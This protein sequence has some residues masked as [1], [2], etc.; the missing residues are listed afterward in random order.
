MKK[1]LFL[2]V[3]FTITGLSL[4]AQAPEVFNYSA[5]ARNGAGQP[6]I[7]QTIAIQFVI[8]KTSNLGPVLYT[9]NHIV[10]TDA[11]GLFNLPV[12]GGSVLNGSMS[13]INWS[14][15][16]YYLEVKLDITGGA[17]FATMGTTQLL[18]VPYALHAKTANDLVGKHYI[19]EQFG[20][21][22]IFHLWRDQSGEEH[23]LIVDLVDLGTSVFMDPT[24]LENPPVEIVYSLIQEFDGSILSDIIAG[25]SVQSAASLC[26]NSTN[27]GFSDWYLPSYYE[28][29]LLKN[30][31]YPVENVLRSISNADALIPEN[32]ATFESAFRVYWTS[33]ID[34]PDLT[35]RMCFTALDYRA[36]P[37]SNENNV[38]AIRKF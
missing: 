2:A 30:N 3:L 14:I 11:Y 24:S 15:D 31:L 17:N 16:N 25:N 35:L 10:Q 26:L 27:G 22:V 28:M 20:G 9:E 32:D 1:S 8:R 34:G 6:V 23:G 4:F 19:G 5:I 36:F 7:N 33:N 18:S 13:A 21:G 12:G 37:L 38:R 29:S